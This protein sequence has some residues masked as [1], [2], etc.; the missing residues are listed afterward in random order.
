MIEHKFRVWDGDEIVGYA[1]PSGL[2]QGY[3][4]GESYGYIGDLIFEQFAGIVDKNGIEIYEGDI[5]LS[6]PQDGGGTCGGK[7]IFKVRRWEG[8]FSL[9]PPCAWDLYGHVTNEIIGN[10][11]QNPELI[12]RVNRNK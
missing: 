8:G 1:T 9:F 4:G 3:P 11:H 5:I 12:E 6:N 7:R 2:L 10:I